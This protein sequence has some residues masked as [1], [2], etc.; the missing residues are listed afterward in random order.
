LTG[1][2]DEARRHRSQL[3]AVTYK[4]YREKHVLRQMRGR[5]LDEQ[6]AAATFSATL[7]PDHPVTVDAGGQRPSAEELEKYSL[8]KHLQV[9]DQC[10][11]TGNTR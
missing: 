1:L 10:T 4:L 2:T 9:T 8:V 5:R 6:N 11:S 3:A 7:D